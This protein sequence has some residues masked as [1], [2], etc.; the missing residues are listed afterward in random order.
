MAGGS[1]KA[2][3]AGRTCQMKRLA[4][5]LGHHGVVSLLCSGLYM[6]SV[7]C[8]PS[9]LRLLHY[10]KLPHRPCSHSPLRILYEPLHVMQ[11]ALEYPRLN[12]FSPD[13]S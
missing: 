12:A 10:P 1:T 4:V 2:S 5:V 6:L 9:Y 8:V 3:A 7:R 13:S 11:P